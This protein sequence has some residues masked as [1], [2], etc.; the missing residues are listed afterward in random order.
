MKPKFSAWYSQVI[1]SNSYRLSLA[2]ATQKNLK[3]NELLEV[4]A[5][6]FSMN[7]QFQDNYS[8]LIERSQLITR[9]LCKGPT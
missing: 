1:Y 5:T 6:L 8:N 2:L 4:F 9:L 3:K 7:M